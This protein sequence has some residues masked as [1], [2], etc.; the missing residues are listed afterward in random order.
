MNEQ[1]EDQ[2]L[3][4]GFRRMSASEKFQRVIDLTEFIYQLALSELRKRHPD[5]DDRRLRLLLASRWIPPQLMQ[6][7]FGWSPEREGI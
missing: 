1:S 6:A 3:I 2:I 4:E 5:L 7:A